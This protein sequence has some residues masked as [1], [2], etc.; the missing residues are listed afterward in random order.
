MRHFLKSIVAL[1]TLLVLAGCGQ[2]KL[3]TTKTQYRPTQMMTVIKGQ[4]SHGAQLTYQ[5]NGQQH[6]LKNNSGHFVLLVPASDRQQ[7]VRIKA[8]QGGQQQLKTVHVTRQPAITSYAALAL[9]YNGGLAQM[10]LT[11]PQLPQKA[12]TGIHTAIQTTAYQLRLNVQ[13]QQVINAAFIVPLKTM[14][15]TAGQ[16]AF[17]T[18]FS[19]VSAALGA[20]SQQ[21]LKDFQKGIKNQQKDQT[22]FKTIRSNGITYNVSFSKTQLY[23]YLARDKG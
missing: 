21:V 22:T 8:T 9:K 23:I 2:L 14:K 1:G 3:T 6:T 18:T 19:L 5:L 15:Q 11:A 7:A 12:A 16:K 13:Q 10:R 20:N 17:G 4:A